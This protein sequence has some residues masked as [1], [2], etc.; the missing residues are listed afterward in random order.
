MKRTWM[1]GMLAASTLGVVACKS[2]DTTLDNADQRGATSDTTTG[3]SASASRDS[4]LQAK[5]VEGVVGDVQEDSF[6]VK[7]AAGETVELK[8]D[9]NAMIDGKPFSTGALVEGSQ[10]RASYSEQGGDNKVSNIEHLD[11]KPMDQMKP[12]PEGGEKTY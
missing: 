2:R 8:I 12:Q 10:V 5:S 7:T 3:T 4:E 9:Q 6:E 11:A 1:L